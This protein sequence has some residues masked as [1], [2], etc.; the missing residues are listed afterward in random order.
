LALKIF[1]LG[2]KTSGREVFDDDDSDKIRGI[3]KEIFFGF[4]K[5]KQYESY[6]P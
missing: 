6:L 2:C 3:Y 1:D 5:I 4:E